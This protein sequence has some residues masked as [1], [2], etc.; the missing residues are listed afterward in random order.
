[1]S[2][3]TVRFSTFHDCVQC[4]RLNST[5]VFSTPLLV[6]RNRSSTIKSM[7]SKSAP[8]TRSAG[9]PRIDD[10]SLAVLSKVRRLGLSSF[11]IWILK[12]LS[13]G[14][15]RPN[16]KGPEKAST[17]AKDEFSELSSSGV[18]TRGTA[19]QDPPNR[20]RSSHE[21]FSGETERHPS[22]SLWPPVRTSRYTSVT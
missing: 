4:L 14:A 20:C 9:R 16:T 21:S 7:A 22:G 11:G 18:R 5:V 6:C 2:P 15:Q 17:Q 10:P 12:V 3:F 8:G 13:L 1:M 19:T